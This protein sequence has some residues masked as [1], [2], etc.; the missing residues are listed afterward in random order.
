VFKD[1]DNTDLVAWRDN[2]GVCA[3]NNQEA[4]KQEIHIDDEYLPDDEV[5]KLF[6]GYENRLPKKERQDAREAFDKLDPQKRRQ[7]VQVLSD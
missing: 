1:T 7:M 2:R 3:R 6:Q 5:E 4:A